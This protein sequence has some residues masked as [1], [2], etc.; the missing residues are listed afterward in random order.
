VKQNIKNPAKNKKAL[1]VARLKA[2]PVEVRTPEQQLAVLDQR[3][4][5]ALG[6]VR[7]RIKLFKQITLD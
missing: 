7:E 4:G 2:R 5:F 3:L 6:A 1:R